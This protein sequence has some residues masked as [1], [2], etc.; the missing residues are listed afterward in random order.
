MDDR[1]SQAGLKNVAKIKKKKPG[2]LTNSTDHKNDTGNPRKSPTLINGA[3]R[4]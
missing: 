2:V 1:Q 4:F 3:N